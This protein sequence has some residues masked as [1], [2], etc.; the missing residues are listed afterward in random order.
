MLVTRRGTQ[1]NTDDDSFH[2]TAG[3][4]LGTWIAHVL[5]APHACSPVFSV[6]FGAMHYPCGDAMA[7]QSASEPSLHDAGD[8]RKAA[9]PLFTASG[10]RRSIGPE[11]VLSQERDVARGSAY[12]GGR[13]ARPELRTRTAGL[14]QQ[15]G[16]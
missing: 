5:L 4:F 7:T 6:M 3:W 15:P 1:G 10:N 16:K 11:K 8:E 2:W 12:A 14:P 9:T 13:T